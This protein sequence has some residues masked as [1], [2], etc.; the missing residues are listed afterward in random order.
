MNQKD[1]IFFDDEKKIIHDDC[2][3]ATL[4][5]N[6]QGP[7]DLL[8]ALYESLAF[9][10][11][12]GFN[13]NALFDCLGDFSW[14]KQREVFLIHNDLPHL[15]DD[16]MQVYLDVLFNSINNWKPDEEHELKVFFPMS[17]KTEIDRLFSR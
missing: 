7:D 2:F 13:W 17:A 11:W 16:Q 10:G 12:F 8:M 1:F 6:L 9:P 4:P 15:S 14:V 5:V 3:L